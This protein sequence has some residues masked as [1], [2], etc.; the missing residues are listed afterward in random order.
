MGTIRHTDST[1][2]LSLSFEP[3]LSTRHQSLRECVATGVYTRGLGRVAGM[4][5]MSS[6][7][8]SEK[9][10]GGND[11]KRDVGCDDLE[12]YIEKTN[13]TAPIYYLID[14][15]L[16]DPAV[17]QQEAMAR[18]ASFADTLPALMVQAGLTAARKST[19]A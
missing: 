2:Q 9:L 11:R 18:L 16:R 17:T 1:S 8:L 6:S 13:D 15:F 19:R 4:I 3:G 14:K 7:K 10:S 5:D 12:R